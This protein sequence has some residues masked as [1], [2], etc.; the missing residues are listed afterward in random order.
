MSVLIRRLLGSWAIGSSGAGYVFSLASEEEADCG[1]VCPRRDQQVPLSED[2][3]ITPADGA[4]DGRQPRT[5]TP[6]MTS[7]TTSSRRTSS[8]R[9]ARERGPVRLRRAACGRARA[10]AHA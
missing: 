7:R 3:E 6:S 10:H 1:G 2:L 8:S 5:R 9:S 4:L